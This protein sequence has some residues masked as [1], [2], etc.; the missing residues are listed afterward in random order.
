MTTCRYANRRHTLPPFTISKPLS[1]IRWPTLSFTLAEVNDLYLPKR[2]HLHRLPFRFSFCMPAKS[3][4]GR[5]TKNRL[6][7]RGGCETLETYNVLIAH[8]Y[9]QRFNLKHMEFSHYIN[10]SNTIKLFVKPQSRFLAYYLPA[11]RQECL[12]ARFNKFIY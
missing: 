6:I 5:K 1:L 10:H 12:V 4:A 11:G 9:L 8:I 7:V 2:K 3:Q